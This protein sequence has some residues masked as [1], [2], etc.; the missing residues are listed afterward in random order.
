MT[1]NA[2]RVRERIARINKRLKSELPV[3]PIIV[4][5]INKAAQSESTTVAQIA[6]IILKDQSITARVLRM[7]NSA[8][9]ASRNKVTTVSR[10]VIVLGFNTI[11][12]LAIS[13]SLYSMLDKSADDLKEFFRHSISVAA[14]SKLLAERKRFAAGEE[15][16]IAGLLH[17]IGR[18]VLVKYFPKAYKRIEKRAADGMTMLEAELGV[19]GINHAQLGELVLETWNLPEMLREP[20]ARHHL[21]EPDENPLVNLVAVADAFAHELWADR[22][23]QQSVAELAE[24][25]LQLGPD[26]LH[27]ERVELGD[28][29][30]EYAQI[31]D[32][33][34]PRIPDVDQEAVQA[35]QKQVDRKAL[36]L[37]CLAEISQAIVA[38]KPV[39]TILESICSGVRRVLGFDR[40]LL[41][42]ADDGREQLTVGHGRGPAADEVAAALVLPLKRDSGVIACC[43]LDLETQN[44]IDLTS[45]LYDEE[46]GDVERYALS[47]DAFACVPI[48]RTG[49]G[50]GTI[51]VDNHVSSEPIED[52]ALAALQAFADQASM[53][54]ALVDKQSADASPAEKKPG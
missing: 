49:K 2:S 17:D 40:V 19:L 38:G 29:L 36:E 43:V 4:T 10:A 46:V 14:I 35:H 54:L 25:R 28:R 50:V 9:Y 32:I 37:A 27:G 18:L 20:V 47:C 23:E 41:M 15:A 33:E 7:V 39:A 5:E 45:P 21:E 51:V 24:A 1:D 53:A 30:R 16:F 44:I 26:E 52:E 34:V 11:R 6:E 42:L 8:A 48:V 22:Q 12:N 3:L 31:F 13:L